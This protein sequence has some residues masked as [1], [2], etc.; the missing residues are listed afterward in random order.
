MAGP[1]ATARPITVVLAPALVSL[2][3]G[4]AMRIDVHAATVDQLIDAL[5]ARWPGM[6]D[7]LRDSSPSVRRHINIFCNGERLGLGATLPDGAEVFVLTA[8]SGG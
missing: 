6:G 7:R 8:V 3:P 1:S 2:F 5:D 4:S